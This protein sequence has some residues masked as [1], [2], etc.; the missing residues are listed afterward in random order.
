MTA[1][2]AIL[3]ELR[4]LRREVAAVH[5]DVEIIREACLGY[6]DRIARLE[7]GMLRPTPTP[8]PRSASESWA[9]PDMGRR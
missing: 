2:A 4:A 7:R 5:A 9:A 6:S 1:T 8:A 3:D